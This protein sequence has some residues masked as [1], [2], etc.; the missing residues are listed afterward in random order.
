M[1]IWKE[2]KREWK[3]LIGFNSREGEKGE[4]EDASALESSVVRSTTISGCRFGLSQFWML[5]N[6]E[7]DDGAWL[8]VCQS[9]LWR[10]EGRKISVSGCELQEEGRE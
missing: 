3:S 2:E 7:S 9:A 10:M 1:Q 5:P 6:A 8:D 4:S